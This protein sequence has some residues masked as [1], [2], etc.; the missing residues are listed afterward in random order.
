MISVHG[1]SLDELTQALQQ[2]AV[3]IAVLTDNINTPQVIA[4]HL[5]GLDLP[6][7]Y[8]IWVCENLAGE[9]EQVQAFT[10]EALMETS[11][12]F[13]L[14]NVVILLRCSHREIETNELKQFPLFGLPDRSFL[15]F[16]DRPGLMTKR[17]VRLLVLGELALQPD[18]IVWDIGAGTGSVSV[19]IARL[20]PSSQVYAIEQTAAGITLIEQNSQCFQVGNITPIYGKAPEILHGIP[21]PDRI[22][23][24]GSSGKL[25]EILDSCQTTLKPGGTIVLAL[26]TLEHLTLAMHWLQTQPSST[27]HHR[28]LQVQLSRSVPVGI[29]GQPGPR[30]RRG[31]AGP[32][33]R[34]G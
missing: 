17:E 3:K 21:S 28:L 8:Q 14:L 9:T 29:A 23:I 25:P 27:W 30:V 2:G 20:C 4:R 16:S 5:M 12:A 7:R 18:Q 13:A 33:R 34:P 15:S 1:R 31:V 11:A 32:V 19:E 10:P 6:T 24:G 22:F 26:A